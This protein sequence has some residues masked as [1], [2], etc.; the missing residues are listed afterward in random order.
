MTKIN[1]DLLLAMADI[2]DINVEYGHLPTGL[3]GK[4]IKAIRV[5]VSYAS[6]II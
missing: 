3:L 5:W 4:P 2:C 1:L 6:F